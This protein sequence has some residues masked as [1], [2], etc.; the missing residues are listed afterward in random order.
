VV[1]FCANTLMN[2]KVPAGRYEMCTKFWLEH[3]RE[4]TTGGPRGRYEDSIKN[5]C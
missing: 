4:E 1:G 3:L 2:L 5:G